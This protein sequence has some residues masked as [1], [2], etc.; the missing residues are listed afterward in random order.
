MFHQTIKFKLCIFSSFAKVC[1]ESVIEE[2]ENT[3]CDMVC[4]ALSPCRDLLANL[5]TLNYGTA[6]S[7]DKITTIREYVVHQ[8]QSSRNDSGVISNTLHLFKLICMLVPSLI[9]KLPAWLRVGSIQLAVLCMTVCHHD[10]V[11]TSL[12]LSLFSQLV[13]VL[14]NLPCWYLATNCRIC[15]AL[16][17][18]V[19][20]QEHLN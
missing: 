17:I 12:A 7:L 15:H 6:A 9:Y 11:A 19:Q 14:F 16:N 2:M 4:I 13:S 5:A 3:L 1:N 10:P 18:L 8:L 20:H